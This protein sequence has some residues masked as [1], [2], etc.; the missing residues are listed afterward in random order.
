MLNYQNN[1]ILKL[2][3]RIGE[4]ECNYNNTHDIYIEM[5]V[6]GEMF[7]LTSSRRGLFYKVQVGPLKSI[8]TMNDE[9]LTKE[10]NYKA[11]I[12]ADIYNLLIT[13]GD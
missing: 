13:R 11:E 1:K 9:E 6:D 10:L 3:R 5:S 2:I 4:W 12:I 7:Y 8:I